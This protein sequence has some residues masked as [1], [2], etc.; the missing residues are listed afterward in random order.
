MG[1]HLNCLDVFVVFCFVD[2]SVIGFLVSFLLFDL[3]DCLGGNMDNYV[4]CWNMFG[5]VWGFVLENHWILFLIITAWLA[6]PY[7]LVLAAKVK[8]LSI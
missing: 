3:L 7:S 1:K 6:R 8:R 2:V 5:F 4:L